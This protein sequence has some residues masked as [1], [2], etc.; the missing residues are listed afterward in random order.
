MITEWQYHQAIQAITAAE[1]RYA[2]LLSCVTLLND[3]TLRGDK[4]KEEFF[5]KKLETTLQDHIKQLEQ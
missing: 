1:R 5:R 3:A 2:Q 4:P